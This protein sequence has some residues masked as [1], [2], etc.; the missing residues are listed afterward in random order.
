MLI[1]S[2]QA[3]CAGVAF[4]ASR[5][6][7]RPYIRGYLKKR[8]GRKFDAIDAAVSRKGLQTT[9]LLRLSPIIP[10]GINNY[11]CGCTDIKLWQWVLGTW[12]GVLPGTTAY[13]NVGSLGKKMNDQS[14][15]KLQK[16]V[17]ALQVCAGLFAVYYLSRLS[18]RALQSDGIGD[19]D[20]V[21]GEEEKNNKRAEKRKDG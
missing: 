11:L 3:I 1:T 6:V 14:L 10:F 13:C 9:I 19:E 18:T 7:V 5:H 20:V 12:V 15:T 2:T 8:Y 16:V 4:M 17:M 21:V